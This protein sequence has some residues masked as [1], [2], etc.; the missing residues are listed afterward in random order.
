ARTPAIG[1]A[2]APHLHALEEEAERVAAALFPNAIEGVRDIN[3]A[4]W[5][6]RPL[7][8]EYGRTLARQVQKTGDDRLPSADIARIEATANRVREG[9]DQVD[10]LLNRLVVLDVAEGPAVR[11]LI[12]DARTTLGQVVANARKHAADKY[13]PF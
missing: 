1:E 11:T 9:F 6:F 2:F 3:R 13:K 5:N 4:L 8:A 7:W 10:Q 12:H